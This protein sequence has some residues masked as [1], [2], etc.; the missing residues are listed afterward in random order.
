MIFN[1]LTT[2]NIRRASI[3]GWLI[4]VLA[5]SAV[6]ATGGYYW[7]SG[8]VVENHQLT[9]RIGRGDL[10]VSVLEQGTLE[11]S[12]NTEIKCEVRGQSMVTYVVP[13]GTYVA[14]GDLLVRLDTKRLEEEIGTQ[15]TEAHVAR[16]T[17]ERTK[18]DV[19]S[20][21]IAIDAYLKGTYQTELRSLEQQR[22]I[23]VRNLE[24]AKESLTDTEALFRRG[25]ASDLEIEAIGFN[26]VHA[27]LDLK[28]RDTAINVL[29]KYT[30]EMEL[31]TLRGN[32]RSLTSK[33]KADEAGL[34]M[35][36]GRRDRAIAELDLCEI[37]AER[38]GLV[39]YPSAAA[40]RSTPDVQEGGSVRK[41]QVLL[42]MPDVAKMQVKVGIH[43]SVVDQL[44]KGMP[45]QITLPDSTIQGKVKTIASVARPAGWWTGNMV[46]YDTVIDLPSGG[47]VKPGMS[48]EVEI[49]ISRH[50]D[51][52][53]VPVSAVVETNRESFCW[54]KKKDNQVERRLLELGPSNDVFIVVQSGLKEDDEVILD[55]LRYFDVET[56][57][58][59]GSN[60]G[61]SDG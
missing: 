15:T 14:Q 21:E 4:F 29:N 35:D 43:E 50:E 58:L 7:L 23:A 16:A 18:A 3:K 47:N 26:V 55:P 57:L 24:D 17:Y 30:K 38:S 36:E 49:I 34:R 51:E 56:E 19:A 61:A 59:T 54:V 5:V 33:L 37:R 25:F 11:S 9:Y 53:L 12:N 6:L 2:R 41:D 48:A 10:V 45:A 22:D 44:N 52:L 28:V 60:S 40:W 27:E 46:K 31:E 1:R 32:L 42:L 20:A 13:S 39:I 8:T